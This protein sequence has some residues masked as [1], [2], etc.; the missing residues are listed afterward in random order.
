MAHRLNITGP[1][2]YQFYDDSITYTG[3][4]PTSYTSIGAVVF[5]NASPPTIIDPAGGFIGVAGFKQI[6]V[7]EVANSCSGNSGIYLTT[8][9][10]AGRITLHPLHTL[11]AETAPAGGITISTL[12]ISSLLAHDSRLYNVKVNKIADSDGDSY[13]AVFGSS[14][15]GDYIKF[16]I[17]TVEVGKFTANGLKLL[18]TGATVNEFS[19]DGTMAGNSDTAVPTEKAVVTYMSIDGSG[20]EDYKRY[21]HLIG[22]I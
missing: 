15:A 10:T 8:S 7:I 11:T 6:E 18:N 3:G 9:I 2:H 5:N 14:C 21:A 1:T 13:V 12:A 19:T 16:V 17:D 4:T 22:G 20:A